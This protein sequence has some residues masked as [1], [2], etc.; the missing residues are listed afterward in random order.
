M[1][2]LTGQSNADLK[3]IDKYDIIISKP[4]NWDILSRRWK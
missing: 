1:C 4:E 2:I 3:L